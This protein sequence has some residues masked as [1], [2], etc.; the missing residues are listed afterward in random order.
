MIG[1]NKLHQILI[2]LGYTPDNHPDD[3]RWYSA[4]KE[5]EYTSKFLRESTWEAP[6][7]IMRKGEFTHGHLCYKEITWRVE[8]NNYNFHCPYRKADCEFFHPLLKE[9]KIRGK[10]SWQMTDKP[11]DY[12]NSAEKLDDDRRKLT[13]KNLEKRFGH[14]GMI[15]CICCHI[16]EQTCE[17]YFSFSPAECIRFMRNGCD[18]KVCYCTGKQRNLQKANIY[19]DVRITTEYRKGFIVEP[20]VKMIKGR[21]LFDNQKAMTDLELYLQCN[22]NAAIGK[23]K[24]RNEHLQPLFFAKYYNQRYELQVENV[25]IEKRSTRDLMQDLMD[26]REGIT[27]LHESDMVKADKAGKSQRRKEALDKRIKKLEAK[28]LQIGYEGLDMADQRRCQKWLAPGRVSELE[29][30]RQKP[31]PEE[32]KQMELSD[33]L[34]G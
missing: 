25:R 29:A 10:C 3:V 16:N 8:N 32:P 7:G 28:I 26:V 4:G 34:A 30:E 24:S 9:L 12:N 20:V 17:P 5:F 2:T 11:Y 22:P 21:K 1:D 19:Y 18:N 6:C 14:P 31:R 15:H 23:E 13:L 27:V 33:F